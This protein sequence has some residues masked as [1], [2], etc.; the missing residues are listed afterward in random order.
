M[1][2]IS[3]TNHPEIPDGCQHEE[4]K[5]G[6]CAYTDGMDDPDEFGRVYYFEHTAILNRLAGT[7]DAHNDYDIRTNLAERRKIPRIALAKTDRRKT[8]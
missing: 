7:P 3:N 5:M 2:K 8:L 6:I 1:E 4:V